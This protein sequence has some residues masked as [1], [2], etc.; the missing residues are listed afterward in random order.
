MGGSSGAGGV[1]T[2]SLSSGHSSSLQAAC[3]PLWAGVSPFSSLPAP[4]VVPHISPHPFS[5]T[6]HQEVAGKMSPR[7]LWTF[8]FTPC[9]LKSTQHCLSP[10]N[11][12]DPS[13]GPSLWRVSFRKTSRSFL[14]LSQ[15]PPTGRFTYLHVLWLVHQG[16]LHPGAL[17]TCPACME[18]HA[19]RANV[20]SDFILVLT[21]G[22]KVKF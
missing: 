4:R 16:S 21:A 1:S 18:G 17:W 20:C 5:P 8:N 12:S 22:V 13:P 10:R 14:S 7:L 15:S 6:G 3:G 11:L 19:R 9:Q 2:S